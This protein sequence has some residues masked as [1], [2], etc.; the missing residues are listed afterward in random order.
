MNRIN[1]L[2]R[3]ARDPL[4][5]MDAFLIAHNGDT[6]FEFATEL[7]VPA[8]YFTVM[9]TIFATTNS[10]SESPQ[11]LAIV[12]AVAEHERGFYNHEKLHHFS[13]YVEKE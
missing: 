8:S 4:T 2:L 9:N 3:D 5:K 7:Y 12:R 1:K 11:S 10:F 6:R 13:N